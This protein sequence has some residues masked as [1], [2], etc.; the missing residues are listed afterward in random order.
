MASSLIL[1]ANQI[2]IDGPDS[3]F[4]VPE[5]HRVCPYGTAKMH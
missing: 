3:M 2:V 5:F 1:I 4:S